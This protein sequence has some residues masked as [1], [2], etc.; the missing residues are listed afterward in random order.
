MT[1]YYF[2]IV[3]FIVLSFVFLNVLVHRYQDRDKLFKLQFG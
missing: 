2:I 3:V 1:V